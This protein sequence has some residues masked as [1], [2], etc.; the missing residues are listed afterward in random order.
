MINWLDVLLM[1]RYLSDI[2][3]H[4]LTQPM[5][6]P[7]NDGRN[8]I[9]MMRHYPGLG[10][11]SKWMKQIFNQSEALPRSESW[12]IIIMEFLWLFLKSHFA[13]KPVLASQN[14]SCFLRL[15]VDSLRGANKGNFQYTEGSEAEMFSGTTQ[16]PALVL[17]S[18]H[19]CMSLF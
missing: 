14:E 11:A 3:W 1:I 19:P 16:F 6:F 5:V 7:W 17:G 10:S 15:R 8:S 2:F 18:H 4:F 9:L 12:H 13:G